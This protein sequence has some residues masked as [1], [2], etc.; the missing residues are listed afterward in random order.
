VRSLFKRALL[1]GVAVATAVPAF[2]QLTDAD[3]ER[4]RA[5]LERPAPTLTLD[6]PTPTFRVHIVERRP[7]QEMFEVPPWKLDKPGWQPPA[8]GFDLLSI[9]RYAAREMAQAKRGHDLRE[10]REE[11]LREIAAYCAAQPNN[12][13]GITV[14]ANAASIR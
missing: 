12:G 7:L 8:V 5:A 10:A 3:V 14:C 11:V 9:A 1:C 13:A 2:A 6:Y 4:I